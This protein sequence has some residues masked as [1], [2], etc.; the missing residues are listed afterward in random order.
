MAGTEAADIPADEGLVVQAMEPGDAEAALAL[1]DQAGWNQTVEDWRFMLEHGRAVGLREP[2]GG[3]VGSSLIMP[4]GP[5]LSWISMVLIDRNWRRQGLGTMLLKRCIESVR[6]SGAIP[7]LDATE[8]GR[9]VYLPQGFEDL[10]ALSRWRLDSV[11]GAEPPPAG[12][13]IR[14]MKPEDLG[15]I[16][17]YDEPRSRLLRG[18]VLHYLFESVPDD[19][20]L[21]EVEGR[22]VG[23][24]LGRPGR[25]AAQIGPVVAESPDVALSLISR[26][27]T[28]GA[29]VILDVPDAHQFVS[30]WLQ[31][32]GAVRER[33][34][35][36]MTLGRFPS[37]QDS[38]Y[39]YALAGPEL[40]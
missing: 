4:L 12:C 27:T 16:I 6:A 7:G 28:L 8:L 26:M 14:R 35:V 29:P 25:R 10:Y 15:A 33:G 24:A 40:A 39:V 9:P 17:A 13:R 2:G 11:A 18:H 32:H 5:D 1:S 21:A 19:A 34:F 30:D 38:S 3:W 22:L 20:C 36:R 23:Y 37:L 31:R